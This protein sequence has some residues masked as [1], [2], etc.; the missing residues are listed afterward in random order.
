MADYEIMAHSGPSEARGTTRPD[1]RQLI[2]GK[3]NGQEAGGVRKSGNIY[4]FPSEAA[5]EAEISG[6]TASTCQEPAKYQL[7]KVG[8]YEKDLKVLRTLGGGSFGCSAV[9]EV[10]NGSPTGAIGNWYERVSKGQK[11]IGKRISMKDPKV[12]RTFEREVR[13]LKKLKGVKNILNL[14]GEQQPSR[15]DPYGYI[16]TEI[17]H[18][19][20]V[21]GLTT[22]YTERREWVPEGF[23][24]QLTIDI[25]KALLFLERGANST[26]EASRN[27]H[28]SILHNDIKPDNIF[29]KPRRQGTPNIYPIFVLGDFGLACES[30]EMA[31]P[32]CVHFMSPQRA[33]AAKEGRQEPV[34]LL[35][36]IYSFGT[37]LF[38]IANFDFPFEESNYPLSMEPHHFNKRVPFNGPYASWFKKI[39]RDATSREPSRRPSVTNII[40]A[41]V[42]NTKK[43]G[44]GS[45][46]SNTRLWEVSWLD[47]KTVKKWDDNKHRKAT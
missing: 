35:D 26:K 39:V 33:A 43:Y 4:K 37:T 5:G 15:E 11:V 23:L 18:L 20:D 29:M 36:D 22:Q 21:E 44:W 40:H 6:E 17:C 12:Y 2:L 8:N 27:G 41:F 28:I 10:V 25:S 47:E 3:N 45:G 32:S 34:N 1:E 13:M 38:V 31:I 16:F 24:L 46:G 7:P 19:G 30:N 9:L 42:E 14:L